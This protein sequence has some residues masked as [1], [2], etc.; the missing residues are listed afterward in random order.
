ME[1]IRNVGDRRA[2]GLIV[3]LAVG[4]FFLGMIPLL[5]FAF[6]SPGLQSEGPWGYLTLAFGVITFLL[7]IFAARARGWVWILVIFQTL[8]IAAVLIETFTD[9]LLYIGT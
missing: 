3:A 8:F 9:S 1:P 4:C 7:L 5:A 2:K 6:F